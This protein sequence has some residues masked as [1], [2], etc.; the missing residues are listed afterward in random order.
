M[1]ASQVKL[2]GTALLSSSYPCALISWQYR[3]DLSSS[4]GIKDSM[5]YRRGKAENRSFKTCRG[6]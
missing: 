1:S 6:F 5:S 4:G 2:Y 3:D